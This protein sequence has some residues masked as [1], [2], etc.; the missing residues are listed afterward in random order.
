[1]EEIGITPLEVIE[2][3]FYDT[4][5]RSYEEMNIVE[6]GKTI[7][8][9]INVVELS[10]P[11]NEILTI[12]DL[13]EVIEESYI[14]PDDGTQRYGNGEGYDVIAEYGGEESWYT[15]MNDI[16]CTNLDSK[17]LIS[18]INEEY[19]VVIE[20]KPIMKY[21]GSVLG[22]SQSLYDRIKRAIEFQK[23]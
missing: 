5:E 2:A 4:D 12:K 3:I 7:T 16:A 19:G 9:T 15:L 20:R 11:I 1:M 22:L 6:D 14:Y 8:A 13:A 10:R 21:N 18:R 23:K 17:K